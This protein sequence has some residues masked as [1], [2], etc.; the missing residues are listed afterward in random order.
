MIMLKK[1]SSASYF[2]VNDGDCEELGIKLGDNESASH[3][4]LSSTTIEDTRD[5]LNLEQNN[6]IIITFQKRGST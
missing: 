1:Q 3:F 6:P 5:S 4:P 2:Q